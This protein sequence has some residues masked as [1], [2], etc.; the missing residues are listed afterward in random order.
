MVQSL[1][2]VSVIRFL[3]SE[4]RITGTLRG[5][6]MQSEDIDPKEYVRENRKQLLRIVSRSD[7]PYTRACAW[8]L[9]DHYTPDPELEQL[10]DELDNVVNGRGSS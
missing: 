1:S 2:A 3:T 8:A 5:S 7:D 6:L 9:L 4:V 10:R